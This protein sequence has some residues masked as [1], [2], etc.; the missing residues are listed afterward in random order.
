MTSEYLTWFVLQD[1][2]ARMGCV[3]LIYDK[4]LSTINLSVDYQ[5]DYERCKRILDRIGSKTFPEIKLKDIIDSISDEE[6]NMMDLDKHIKLPEGQSIKLSEYLQ[7]FNERKYIIR[8]KYEI[9]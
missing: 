6:F 3:D 8:Y 4:P 5:E 1:A 7:K 2:D 9:L